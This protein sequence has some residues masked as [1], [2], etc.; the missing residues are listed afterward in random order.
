VFN[1]NKIINY[2]VDKLDKLEADTKPL[3]G[4]MTPQHMIEHLILAIQAGNGKL[5]VECFNPEEKLPVLKRFLQS[6][7]ELPK[8]FINPLI[9]EDLLPL[10]FSDLNEAKRKLFS[11][12]EVHEMFFNKNPDA[13]T[14][15]PTFGPLNKEEWNRFHE[16]HF[17]HHLK[18][19]GLI[20]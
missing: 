19:F 11:E 15:N 5:K 8:E 18:Q 9:G 14:T 6:N 16:K 20:E 13:L 4:K 12:I 3:W 10:K 7:R 17:K 2:L 1:L